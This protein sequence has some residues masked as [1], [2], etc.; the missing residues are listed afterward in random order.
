MPKLSRQLAALF[1]L[2][3]LSPVGA[4]NVWWVNFVKEQTQNLTWPTCPLVSAIIL[5]ESGGNPAAKNGI[6]TGLMQVNGYT[7]KQRKELLNPAVNI[8]RGVRL[9]RQYYSLTKSE[10]GAIKAYNVGIGTYFK[11]MVSPAYYNKVL[12]KVPQ[13]AKLCE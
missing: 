8:E 10:K 11:I 5:V 7:E 4:A 1:L 13:G 6:S 2:F 3:L 9:L 12:E